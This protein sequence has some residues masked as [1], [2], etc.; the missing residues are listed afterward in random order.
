M[1][2]M[3]LVFSAVALVAA[4]S[5]GQDAAT[6]RAEYQQQQAIAE[7]PR[8]IQQFDQLV[9]NQDAIAQRLVKLESSVGPDA[10][11]QAEIA[12]L[13]AEIAD[14][15]ASIRRDQDAMRAEIVRD[16]AGRIAKMTP[17]PAPAPAPVAPAPATP[18]ATVAAPAPAPAPAPIGPHW[19]YKVEPGQ[20]LSLIAQGFGTTVAK[21]L[22]ANPKLKPNALR[23]G[24]TI[25]IPAPP[26]A[27][28]PAPKATRAPKDAPA[29]KKS[30]PGKRR[31]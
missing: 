5:F 25:I 22:A 9:Q 26:D 15:R 12:A 7:V 24:Q 1:K 30:L 29:S 17:P 10:N 19:E 2:N 18:T 31:R 16:L 6:A 27:Q 20:T 8:L 21:I 3:K 4:A 13:K 11:M 14:L 28:K 23:V